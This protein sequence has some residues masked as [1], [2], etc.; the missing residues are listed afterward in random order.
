MAEKKNNSSSTLRLVVTLLYLE[1]SLF[2]LNLKIVKLFKDFTL[3]FISYNLERFNT[4]TYIFGIGFG[5][6]LLSLV[7]F[8]HTYKGP[9]FTNTEIYATAQS[10]K[11]ASKPISL[12]ISSIGL[13]QQIYQTKITDGNWEISENGVSHLESSAN[14]GDEGAIILY[15]HNTTDRLSRLKQVQ[16]K[17]PIYVTNEQNEEFKYQVYD[18]SIVWPNQTE[19]LEPTHKEELI[20]YTCTG[21]GDIQRLVVKAK[22]I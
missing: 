2:I 14:P 17:D 20:L 16:L 11:L 5:A 3:R 1:I 4:R 10:P 12:I 18:I 6:V 9:T 19:V 21:L 13:E 15:G 22:R 8:F 7:I